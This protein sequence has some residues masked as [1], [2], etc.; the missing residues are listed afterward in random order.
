MET[1]DNLE[2]CLSV[3]SFKLSKHQKEILEHLRSV[4]CPRKCGLGSHHTL[5]NMI[6]A[7]LQRRTGL[8][9]RYADA[10]HLP[11]FLAEINKPNQELH[12]EDL[13]VSGSRKRFRPELMKQT[14]SLRSS[15]NRSLKELVKRKLVCAVRV[16]EVHVLARKKSP[17]RKQY[18]LSREQAKNCLFKANTTGFSIISLADAEPSLVEELNHMVEERNKSRQEHCWLCGGTETL[19]HMVL[20][21]TPCF[22]KRGEEP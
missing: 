10:Q 1:V 14:H 20:V 15:F 13:Y 3:N 17:F 22:N 9:P 12:W 19:S 4:D 7:I 5:N 21:C 6:Y 2:N 18:Y 11:G 16:Q 8:K